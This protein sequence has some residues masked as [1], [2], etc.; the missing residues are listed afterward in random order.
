MVDHDIIRYED[1]DAAIARANSVLLQTLE[2][3]DVMTTMMLPSP[4]EKWTKLVTDYAAILASMAAIARSRFH[5][6]RMR[7]DDSVVQTQHRFDE[8]VNECIIQ[9][10]AIKKI[11][12]T[13]ARIQHGFASKK[14][15]VF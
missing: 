3:K 9:T 14:I 13:P 4:A 1:F 8:M 12:T 7:D 5:D 10:M 11:R 15:G 6:F 2:P